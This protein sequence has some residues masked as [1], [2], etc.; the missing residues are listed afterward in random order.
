MAGKINTLYVVVIFVFLISS[1]DFFG[2][3][4]FSTK[5]CNHD[6]FKNQYLKLL[7]CQT[8]VL[9]KYVD[10][11]VNDYKE[12]IETNGIYDLAKPC[13]IYKR[14]LNVNGSSCLSAYYGECFD[15]KFA[16]MGFELLSPCF[17][18]YDTGSNI[19]NIRWEN[20]YYQHSTA[21]AETALK[22]YLNFDKNMKN[23]RMETYFWI[24][25]PE[26]GKN[27]NCQ[28]AIHEAS[29]AMSWSMPIPGD[30]SFCSTFDAI[31]NSCS[32]ENSCFSQR[33]MDL[34]KNV[35]KILYKTAMDAVVRTHNK[36]GGKGIGVR[37]ALDR[38]NSTKIKIGNHVKDMSVYILTGYLRRS[39]EIKSKTIDIYENIIEDYKTKDCQGIVNSSQKLDN[40]RLHFMFLV[41]FSICLNH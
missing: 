20:G 33:E 35:L 31:L 30:L 10:M 25:V 39:T 27:Q 1:I 3:N 8:G 38:I 34:I 18:V 22:R 37:N 23:C 4:G 41:F 2:T 28:S 6:Q 7:S 16:K 24:L 36:F 11:L 17:A 12:Q 13:Q 32:I 40:P 26:L 14:M 9:N 21:Q 19:Q 15:N 29:N 5:K